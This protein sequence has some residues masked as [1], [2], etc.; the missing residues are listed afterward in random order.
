[1]QLCVPGF[2]P[3]QD[4]IGHSCVIGHLAVSTLSG[5]KIGVEKGS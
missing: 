5:G 1:M 3:Q 2:M 4:H